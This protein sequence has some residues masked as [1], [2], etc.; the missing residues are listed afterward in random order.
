MM[1]VDSENVELV[2]DLGFAPA[3]TNQ[4][5]LMRQSDSGA[6]VNAASRVDM[7]YVASDPLSELVWSPHKG[8]SLKCTEC[9]FSEKKPSLLQE[10]GPSNMVLSP[11]RSLTSRGSTGDKQ[12]DE[13]NLI[14]MQVG[15]NMESEFGEGTNIVRS[16]HECHGD[17]GD[18]MVE[19]ATMGGTSVLCTNQKV[20][21]TNQT[22]GEGLCSPNNYETTSGAGSREN[23]TGPENLNTTDFL[24]LSTNKP[25]TGKE[26]A[27][28]S[29]EE[30][31]GAMIQW[32]GL[33]S[34]ETKLTSSHMKSKNLSSDKE[35]R[36]KAKMGGS[37]CVLPLEKLE[38]TAENDLELVIGKDACGQSEERLPSQNSAPAE[39]SPTNS[40]TS[41]YRRKGKEKALSDGD[42]NQRLSKDEDDSHESVESCNSAGLFSRGKKRLNFREQLIVGSKRVKRQIHE[43]PA[44][45]SFVRQ[46]S[47]FMNWISNMVNGLKNTSEDENPSLALT[48]APNLGHENRSRN[49]GFQTIFQSLYCPNT[50]EEE[51]KMLNGN[52]STEGSKQLE[53]APKILGANVAPIAYHRDGDSHNRQSLLSNKKFKLFAAEMGKTSS[54]SDQ[55]KPSC[56]IACLNV[57]DRIN[58]SSSSMGKQKIDNGENNDSYPSP[59][60]KVISDVGYRP[61]PIGSLWI[62]R[63]APKTSGPMLNLDPCDQNTSGA[64]ESSTNHVDIPIEQKSSEGVL[65]LL[66]KEP[67]GF[68]PGSEASFGLK[69]IHGQNDQKSAY[70]FNPILPFSKFKSTEAMASVFA[71]R[72]DALKHIIPSSDVKDNAIQTTTCFYCGSSGH[73][74]HDCLEVAEMEREN[75]IRN[76]SSYDGVEASSCLCIRCFRL[77][78]WAISCPLLSRTIQRQSEND[79]TFSNRF[80][81][82]KVPQF[83]IGNERCH[84]SLEIKQLDSQVADAHTNY[85]QKSHLIDSD[86]HI[87]SSSS[88]YS[89]FIGKEITPLCSLVDR[90]FADV[91]KGIFDAIRKIRLSRMDVLKWINSHN[92]PFHLDGFFLR[93]RLGKWEEG[94][95]GTGYHVACITEEQREKAPKGSKKS[96]AV[97][98]GGIKCLVESQY[99]SNQDF[100]EDELM[101]WWC[102]TMRSGGKLPSE[103]HLKLKFE[104]RKRL[105]F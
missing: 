77:D 44:S 97:N 104:E 25:K 3:Y 30:Q 9:S 52:S 36:S 12:M 102:T 11:P 20:E 19:M 81:A 76:V 85:D 4:C 37:T 39:S 28:T 96:L 33:N 21:K 23:F 73:D 38:C 29:T 71:R 27:N 57:K 75:L 8:L 61:D 7:T 41:L 80:T 47:S 93:L 2:T 72:L 24:M 22:D 86:K 10:A 15:V 49:M 66:G 95:G 43:S 103:D 83:V 99:I 17:G 18:C 79:S 92:S 40:R 55:N 58:S 88:G 5:I 51:T 62:T 64:L 101:A 56:N 14:T 60:A 31:N 69:A 65:N 82:S 1:N 13:G 45:T 74:L 63:L 16:R 53:P 6:G 91:P 59:E 54:S 94:L 89:M 98:I 35:H 68:G 48:L 84:R 32:K 46:D 90:K 67:H 42:V 100:L 70:K 34:P 105:G 78:H 26:E 50:K 87:G